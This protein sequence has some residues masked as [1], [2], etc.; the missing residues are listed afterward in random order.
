M[1]KKERHFVEDRMKAIGAQV[2][3]FNPI[4]KLGI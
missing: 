2:K 3:S 1:Y 4:T